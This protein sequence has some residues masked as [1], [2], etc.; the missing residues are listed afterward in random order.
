MPDWSESYPAVYRSLVVTY[1]ELPR[2][3]LEQALR[4]VFGEA[5][6]LDAVERF[7]DDLGPRPE[8][9][10]RRSRLTSE[11]RSI[12]VSIRFPTGR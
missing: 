5:S 10:R 1:R 2:R 3:Q 11:F 9:G 7:F 12:C 6:S 8:G 4:G